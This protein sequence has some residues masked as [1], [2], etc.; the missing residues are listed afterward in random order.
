MEEEKEVINNENL[1]GNIIRHT[2]RKKQSKNTVKKM[3]IHEDFLFLFFLYM[4]QKVNVNRKRGFRD[5][6]VSRLLPHFSFQPFSRSPYQENKEKKEKKKV[7]TMKENSTL[8]TLIIS[9]Y[10]FL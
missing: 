8:M 10:G 9:F 6:I 5:L 7:R 2:E 1:K 4:F 3:E